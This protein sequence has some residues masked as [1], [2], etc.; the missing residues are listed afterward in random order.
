VRLP[1]GAKRKKKKKKKTRERKRK[2][3]STHSCRATKPLRAFCAKR[4]KKKK[5]EKKARTLVKQGGLCALVAKISCGRERL[6]Q[7]AR[8]Q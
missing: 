3:E 2:K 4:K 5:K 8:F 7:C 6:H 1:H